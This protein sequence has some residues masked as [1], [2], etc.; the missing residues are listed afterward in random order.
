MMPQLKT[1]TLAE[2]RQYADQ[3]ND[4]WERSDV[5]LPTVRAEGVNLWCQSFAPRHDFTALVIE[6]DKKFVAAL[7]LLIDRA[8]KFFTV[9]RLPTNCTVN[10]G[11][12]LVDPAHD[13]QLATQLLAAHLCRLPATFAAFEN[14]AIQTDRWQRFIAALGSEHRELHI[15]P[16]HDVGVIDVFH[17]WQAYTQ[18]WS[19]NFR[20]SLN[21][22]RKKL[23]AAGDVQVSR[24]REPDNEELYRVLEK[25]FA[26][27]DSGWKGASG[28]SIL[29]TP[30]LRDYYHQEAR[31]MRDSG[32]LD[33]WLL[34]LNDQIIAF[35][36]S[37]LSKTTSFSH[38]VSFDPAWEKCSP[39]RALQMYQL[40]QYHQDPSVALID[41]LGVHCEMKA[42]WTTR[43]YKSSR[44]FVAIG[45]RWS[46]SLLA[47][48][49]FVRRLTQASG[50]SEPGQSS[51]KPG[52]EDYLRT[53]R[54]STAG[55]AQPAKNVAPQL[56]VA[57][58]SPATHQQPCG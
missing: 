46:N 14:I 55:D 1:L 58:P 57:C 40:E 38:K 34:T 44:C 42:K 21:R 20:R 5:R 2:L 56:P 13:L 52:A 30:G 10:A 9:Y 4:L 51:I 11:D 16:G 33:L 35:D 12:L 19:R 8:G 45:S 22:S 24:L 32:M 26:I 3:W 31:M 53:A 28:T 43:T 18:C 39:G 37:Q 36:Y 17:N 25:C 29:Q 6:S 48:I 54:E 27:E 50:R 23:E 49:K 41:T 15:S 7:P 47:G